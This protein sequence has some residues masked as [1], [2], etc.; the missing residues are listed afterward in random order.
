MS[1][2]VGTIHSYPANPRV[3][4]TLIAAKYNG[5]TVDYPSTFKMGETNKSADFKQ[6][7]PLGKVPAF[8]GKDGFCLYESSAI[9]YYV[10]SQ[11]SGS[12]LLGKDTKESALIQQYIGVADG[13][14]APNVGGWI[15]P[16][17][18]IVKYNKDQVGQSQAMLE[19]IVAALDKVLLTRTYLVGERITLADVVLSMAFFNA[20]KLVFDADYRKKYVNL[21]RWFNTCIN[22]PHFKS[23]IGEFKM[24]EQQLKFDAKKQAAGK[25]NKPEKKEKKAEKKEQKPAKPDLE[26]EAEA[27]EK[28]KKKEKNPLDSLPPSP[29][30][31]DEWKRFYSNNEEPA[32]CKWFWEN[33]DP[34]GYS[35]WRVEYKYNDELTM[36]VS[37]ALLD[38]HHPQW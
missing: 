37:I 10:A 28:A 31:L 21:T 1:K 12:T 25:E 7:F 29:F 34:E 2:S 30:V 32:S 33:F 23:V 20:F 14:V 19:H 22:Q 3:Y 6:K 8:E 5:L 26:A 27:E 17:I 4:K 18:G 11:K 16:L 13:E 36:T 35:M 9:A 15:Y 38:I 24:C